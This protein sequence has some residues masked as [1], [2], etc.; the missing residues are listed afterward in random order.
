ML[1]TLRFELQIS[2]YCLDMHIELNQYSHLSNR[3]CLHRLFNQ[4]KMS[5]KIRQENPAN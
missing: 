2:P 1:L 5:Q 3:L 4:Y